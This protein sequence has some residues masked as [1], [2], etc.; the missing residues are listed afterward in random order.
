[1]KKQRLVEG[2]FELALVFG[3]EQVEARR[4]DERARF[5]AEHAV[6]GRAGVEKLEFE[7]EKDDQVAGVLRDQPVL[8]LAAAQSQLGLLSL[9]FGLPFIEGVVDGRSQPFQARFKDVV[10]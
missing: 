9:P 6:E 3:M 8:F 2:L 10:L 1:M 7:I 4:A 5:A